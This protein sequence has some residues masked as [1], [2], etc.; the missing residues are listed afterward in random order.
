MAEVVKSKY[1]LLHKNIRRN[2]LNV[3]HMKSYSH[4]G[5]R[6]VSMFWNARE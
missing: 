1:T 4:E 2:T 5:Y 6:K 3:L